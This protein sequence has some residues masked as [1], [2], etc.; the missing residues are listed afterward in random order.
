MDPKTRD[1]VKVGGR[2]YRR[3]PLDAAWILD[4]FPAVPRVERAV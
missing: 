1:Y 2:S 4:R 3:R